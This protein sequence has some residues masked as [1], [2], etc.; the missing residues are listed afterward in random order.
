MIFS[1][2]I[3]SSSINERAEKEWRV[4]LAKLILNI[5]TVN[6]DGAE[7]KLEPITKLYVLEDK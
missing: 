3:T 4:E 6:S 2:V 5:Q 1:L 7:H